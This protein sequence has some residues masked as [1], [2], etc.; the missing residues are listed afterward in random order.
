MA[1]A[2]A[3]T[4]A[5]PAA[6]T[7][8]KPTKA[9]T[10]PAKAIKKLSAVATKPVKQKVE[11]PKAPKPKTPKPKATK[12]AKDSILKQTSDAISQLASD[13]LADRIIPTVEQIKSLAS[14]ALGQDKKKSGKAKRTAK[15]K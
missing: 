9:A 7:A 8:T 15:S 2:P 6:K 1:K 5:K 10:K 4:A 14:S 12:P 11:E 13:I 3:K